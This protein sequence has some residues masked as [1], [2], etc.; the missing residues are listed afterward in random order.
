MVNVGVQLLVH[1]SSMHTPTHRRTHTRAHTHIHTCTHMRKG[2]H[3]YSRTHALAFTN[4]QK[5]SRSHAYAQHLKPTK[6]SCF[7]RKYIKIHPRL[8]LCYYLC[9]L[10][11]ESFKEGLKEFCSI[12]DPFRV[13]SNNPNHRCPT[14]MHQSQGT[15]SKTF[16]NVKNTY[17]L[18]SKEFF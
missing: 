3:R 6:S 11:L 13:F 18:Y 5:H 8:K 10:I 12:V 14:G 16:F 7:L 17:K 4:T 2:T 15:K 9:I 1:T